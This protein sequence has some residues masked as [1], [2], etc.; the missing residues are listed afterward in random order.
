MNYSLSDYLKIATP[1]ISQQLISREFFFYI[2]QI[3]S[4]LPSG[5]TSL[6]GFECRLGEITPKADF[7]LAA[8]ASG[9]GRDILAGKHR[10]IHLPEY[11]FTNSIWRKIRE[12][13]LEWIDPESP[14]YDNADNIWLEFDVDS[15]PPEIPTPSLFFGVKQLQYYRENKLKYEDVRNI[16][17]WGIKTALK[18]LETET[19]LKLQSKISNCF[20]LLPP[21]AEVFQIGVMLSRKSETVRLC[22]SGIP[23]E[24]IVD[25]LSNIG[26]IG[27]YKEVELL[28]SDLSK[29][30]NII[31]L[32]FDVGNTIN[33]KL[34][35]EC[36]TNTQSQNDH[37]LQAFLDYLVKNGMCLPAKRDALLTYPGFF[38]ERSNPE[39]WPS[40]L[41]KMSSF[42]QGNK[43]STFM[44][45][46]NH[47]KIVYEA[48]KALEAKA[49]LFLGHG[50]LPKIDKLGN[51]Y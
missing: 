13:S 5:I 42:L 47:I 44:K 49:Y 18:L 11:L 21:G 17:Q 22:V 50:W 16:S 8:S 12:F 45:S 30:V 27:S 14:L 33:R 32:A 31:D 15:S 43:L 39:F 40:N 51:Y 4:L 3:A 20:S 34:G 37:M 46:L 36:F 25:Y 19:P 2:N 9:N 38:D 6:F 28:V 23:I 48:G 24:K 41:S 29:F 26:W 35:F 7:F 1:H 10:F